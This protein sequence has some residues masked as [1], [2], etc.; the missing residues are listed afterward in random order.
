M[1]HF[2]LLFQDFPCFRINGYFPVSWFRFD[3]ADGYIIGEAVFT[4]FVAAAF[5][6]ALFLFATLPLETASGD[7]PIALKA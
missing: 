4:V 2:V 7:L 5:S 3:V 1:L 6:S